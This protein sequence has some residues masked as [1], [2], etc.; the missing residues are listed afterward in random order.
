MKPCPCKDCITYPVCKAL[1]KKMSLKYMSHTV[2]LQLHNKCSLIDECCDDR[3]E[4]ADIKCPGYCVNFNSTSLMEFYD[5]E[6][7][8]YYRCY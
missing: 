1:V 2:F 5:I 3:E 7:F 4:C 8:Y 6:I